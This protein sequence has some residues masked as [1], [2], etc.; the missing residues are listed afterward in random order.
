MSQAPDLPKSSEQYVLCGYVLEKVYKPKFYNSPF[1]I[2]A[3]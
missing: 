1:I 2:N 3:G